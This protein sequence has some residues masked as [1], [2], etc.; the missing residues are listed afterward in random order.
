MELTQNVVTE[1]DFRRGGLVGRGAVIPN[2]Y[3]LGGGLAS[4]QLILLFFQ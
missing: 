3:I 1:W 4:K 2:L